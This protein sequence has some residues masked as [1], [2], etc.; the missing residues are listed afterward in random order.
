LL[1]DNALLR[2]KSASLLPHIEELSS[3][4]PTEKHLFDVLFIWI[5]LLNKQWKKAQSILVS[6]PESTLAD[7]N[8][9]LYPL[10]GCWLRRMEGEAIAM[11]HFS[12]SIDL[13]HPPTTM[14][15]SFYLQ[16]KIAQKKGWISTA[17]HWEKIQLFRQ[18]HLYYHCAEEPLKAK[19]FLNQMKQELKRVQTPHTHS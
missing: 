7:E 8:S 13:P 14:L 10:M 4:V 18:L 15:L 2:G 11:T 1:I 17:F 6:Y 5:Y 9:P 12:L 19:H 3:S 16:G